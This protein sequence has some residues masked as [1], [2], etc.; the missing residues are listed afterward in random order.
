KL[1]LHLT[2]QIRHLPRATRHSAMSLIECIAVVAV[3]AVMAA[4][5]VPVAIRQLDRVASDQ[6]A[7]SLKSLGDALQASILAQ[8]YIPN[9]T[10]WYSQT[11]TQAGMDVAAVT[12]NLR[13]RARVFLTDASGWLSNSLPY[14]QTY[15]GT[16]SA[17]ANARVV[18]VSSIGAA[19]PMSS[20]MPAAAD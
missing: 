13:N 20:G 9:Q 7:A 2:K 3:L 18:L 5:L 1:K 15:L 16:P 8:R 12:N 11:A 17:P 10:N 14:T 4:A 6:E 19:V